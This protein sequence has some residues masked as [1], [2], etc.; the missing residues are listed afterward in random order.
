V[1]AKGAEVGTR[2][3]A[4]EG[5]ESSVAVFVLDYASELLFVGD[6]GTTE[7]S[8]PSRRVGI[9]WTNHYKPLPWLAF[10][11]DVAATRAR[12]TDIDPAGD[13]I[14]GAPAFVVSGG[15]VF[16]EKTGWFGAVKARYFGR[17]R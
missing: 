8:R 4:I 14:P 11:L 15:L 12:F 1:R 13:R 9:E 6:A 2:T 7:P 17:A 16:G 3:T 5:L 10:D